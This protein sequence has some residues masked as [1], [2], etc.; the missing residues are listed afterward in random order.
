MLPP[1]PQMTKLNST[2]RTT[3]SSAMEPMVRWMTSS[4]LLVQ[5]ALLHTPVGAAALAKGIAWAAAMRAHSGNSVS[6]NYMHLSAA[7][8]QELIVCHGMLERVEDEIL[9]RDKRTA[10]RIKRDLLFWG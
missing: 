9:E 10:K 8:L 5:S 7:H 6:F 3:L 4:R 2:K 1:L